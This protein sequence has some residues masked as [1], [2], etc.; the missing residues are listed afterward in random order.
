MSDPACAHD[1]H[2]PVETLI[3]DQ[4]TVVARLCL[5]CDTQLHPGWGCPACEWDQF[6][7]PRRLCEPLNS[8]DLEHVLVRPCREHA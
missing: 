6:A 7:K 4:V 3:D 1:D 5:G 2:V 8:I